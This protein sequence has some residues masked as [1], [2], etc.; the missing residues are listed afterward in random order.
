MNIKQISKFMSYVLR[1]HPEEAGLT[2][3]EQGWAEA[4]DLL[5]A[6]Q[7]RNPEFTFEDMEGLV[8]ASEK[9]RFQLIDGR[10]RA[11]QGHS[12]SVDLD[13]KPQTPPAVLYHGTMLVI[14]DIIQRDGLKKMARHHVH[15]SP[16]RE[17]ALAVAGRRKGTTVILEVDA[18]TMSATHDFYVSD[19]GVWLTDHVPPEFI[20]L[21]LK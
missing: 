15:L 18:L 16:D 9:Q 4:Q 6:I 8:V 2:L 1:H 11:N 3:D 19:N 12:V 5:L 21:P 13:L 14:L 10:I 7:K 20:K 17:T